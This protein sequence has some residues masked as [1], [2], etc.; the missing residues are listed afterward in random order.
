MP[1][2]I[3]AALSGMPG[4][5]GSTGAAHSSAWPA[6]FHPPTRRRPH[7]PRRP[8]GSPWCARH[9]RCRCGAGQ[10]RNVE[11]PAADQ[12]AHQGGESGD[13]RGGHPSGLQPAGVDTHPNPRPTVR[14]AWRR[15][16]SPA[17]TVRLTGR[18]ASG[19]PT[20]NVPCRASGGP[21][22][23][24]S[25][26]RCDVFSPACLRRCCRGP[27]NGICVVRVP[28]PLIAE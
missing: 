21:A 12:H 4:R 9:H 13:E 19:T 8:A 23:P 27:S 18:R 3:V 20:L 26:D 2:V 17:H 11:E 5:S 25:H 1:D 14:I 28:H 24:R 22:W 15:H 16:R 10:H 7:R 6:A